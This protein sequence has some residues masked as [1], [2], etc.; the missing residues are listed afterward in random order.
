MLSLADHCNHDTTFAKVDAAHQT[1]NI[2]A[3]CIKG[4]KKKHVFLTRFRVS[5]RKSPK[6]GLKKVAI[7]WRIPSLANW[8]KIT[9]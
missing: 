7:K 8:E 5:F 2:P 1:E 3:L 4:P 6:N 9:F